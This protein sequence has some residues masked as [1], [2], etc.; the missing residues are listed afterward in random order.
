MGDART[1]ELSVT[2]VHGQMC[3]GVSVP[4]IAVEDGTDLLTSAAAHRIAITAVCR[5]QRVV[6]VR[7]DPPAVVLLAQ[8][9][10]VK[11]ESF[12]QA[13]YVDVHAMSDR[14]HGTCV[15]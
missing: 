13:S 6:L 9:I 2:V 12:A 8:A 10:V 7:D 3:I 15:W 14:G 4:E 1:E 11:L 5:G